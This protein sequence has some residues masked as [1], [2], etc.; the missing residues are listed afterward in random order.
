MN[1]ITKQDTSVR[2]IAAVGMYDGVHRA[3][4]A[5]AGIENAPINE[6]KK[7]RLIAAAGLCLRW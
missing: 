6:A 5:I 4:A 3:N 2:R 7:A 1:L